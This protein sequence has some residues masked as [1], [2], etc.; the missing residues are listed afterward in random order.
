ME[1]FHNQVPVGF[2]NQTNGSIY[3]ERLWNRQMF[4]FQ[5]HSNLFWFSFYTTHKL[6]LGLKQ[7]QI[8]L[9]KSTKLR[10][11]LS[12]LIFSLETGQKKRKFIVQAIIRY[13]AGD[14]KIL[15]GNPTNNFIFKL[16]NDVFI[17][18]SAPF[19]LCEIT[20]ETFLVQV[21]KE[22]H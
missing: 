11:L 18:K 14:K 21:K 4:L 6:Q 3:S 13:S 19:K 1:L 7:L 17:L 16:K 15:F 12:F 10:F 9:N 5:Q 2:L 8:S 22:P 20:F